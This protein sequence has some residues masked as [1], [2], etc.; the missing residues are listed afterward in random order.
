MKLALL[1]TTK[2]RARYFERALAS[3]IREK[4]EGWRDIEIVISDG[5]STDGTVDIIRQNEGAIGAWISKPDRGVAEGVNRALALAKADFIWPIGDDDVLVPGASVKVM[6][7]LEKHPDIDVLFGR[8]K[9]FFDEEDGSSRE[10]HWNCPWSNGVLGLRNIKELLVND[11]VIP[12]VGFYRRTA[13]L[14]VGGYDEEYHYSAFWD[15]LFKL[16][17]AGYKMVAIPELVLETHQTPL[18]DTRSA[19]TSPRFWKERR[20]MLMANAG[21]Y[22]VFWHWCKGDISL[23]NIVSKLSRELGQKTGIHPRKLRDQLME[24]NRATGGTS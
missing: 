22:W 13:M 14:A 16:V 5:G 19:M 7:Y 17:R 1:M 12:E 23:A 20:R 6:E 8:N 21:P 4:R 11:F 10:I 15:N 24:R 2:N 3:M 9:I 18:S